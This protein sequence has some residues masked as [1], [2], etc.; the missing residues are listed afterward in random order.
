MS[1]PTTR[2]LHRSPAQIQTL[3]TAYDRQGLSAREFARQHEIPAA[4]LGNWLRLRR[5]SKA[6]SQG[7]RWIEVRHPAPA[8][9]PGPVV[10]IE[11]LPGLQLHLASGFPP[12]PVAELIHLLRRP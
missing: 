5:R 9:T 7:P 4:S 3:L 12:G 2:R 11:G 8:A 6:L 10:T 1:S